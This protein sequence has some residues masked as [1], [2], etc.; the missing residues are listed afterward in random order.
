MH[1]RFAAGDL[2]RF[3]GRPTE[4][5]STTR[6]IRH[7][8]FPTVPISRISLHRNAHRFNRLYDGIKA[9][10]AKLRQTLTNLVTSCGYMNG[11]S[12]IFSHLP[13]QFL[14]NFATLTSP[15]Y[16]LH[17][18]PYK[19]LNLQFYSTMSFNVNDRYLEDDKSSDRSPLLSSDNSANAAN[20]GLIAILKSILLFTVH[21]PLLLDAKLTKVAVL[22]HLFPRTLSS[23]QKG[24]SR[25]R[26]RVS[27][28]ERWE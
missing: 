19:G 8:A 26:S 21:T 28:R 5:I 25:E 24:G 18:Q 9:R 1:L 17:L 7:T 22:L 20:V 16:N 6:V 10:D 4:R 3:E 2:S 15:H 27:I 12:A 11:S 13:R 23:L 14:R